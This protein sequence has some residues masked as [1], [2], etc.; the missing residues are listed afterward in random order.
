MAK[1]TCRYLN[2][3]TRTFDV[4]GLPGTEC[5]DITRALT[6]ANDVLETRET[7]EAVHELP[8]YVQDCL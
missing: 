3:G 1:I 2:D 7:E 8:D 4:E 6:Q 5:Q